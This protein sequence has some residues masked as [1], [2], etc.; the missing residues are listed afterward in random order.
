MPSNS[1]KNSAKTL[2][3]MPGPSGFHSILNPGIA[4]S[5]DSSVSA[6]TGRDTGLQIT[7]RNNSSIPSLTLGALL[8]YHQL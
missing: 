1:S 5:H 7:L 4:D 8:K 3:G 2:T 6:L